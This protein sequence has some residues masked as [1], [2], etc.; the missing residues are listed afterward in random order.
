M[1]LSIEGF[2][3]VQ[4]W[5]LDEVA[6]AEQVQAVAQKLEGEGNRLISLADDIRIQLSAASPADKTAL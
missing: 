6:T 2:A 5:L 3:K 1:S 4:Q